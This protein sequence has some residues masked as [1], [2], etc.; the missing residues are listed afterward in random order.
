MLRERETLSLTKPIQVQQK[1]LKGER[2]FVTVSQ[3]IH[4]T[5]KDFKVILLEQE[6][7]QEKRL[8]D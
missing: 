3:E 6:V 4:A 1:D 8:W 7:V 5:K 2:V